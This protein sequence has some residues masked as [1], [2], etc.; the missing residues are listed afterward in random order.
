MTEPRSLSAV[1]DEFLTALTRRELQATTRLLRLYAPVHRELTREAEALATELY[2]AQ[3]RGIDLGPAATARQE[4]VIALRNQIAL[5]IDRFGREAEIT[6]RDLQGV[7]VD[8]GLSHSSTLMDVGL[9]ASAPGYVASFNRLASGALDNLVGQFSDGSPLRDLFQTF[10]PDA[11]S[12]AEQILFRTLATG[13]H[14]RIAA[15]QLQTRLGVP[16]TRA[17]AISRTET[18][19]SY[20]EANRQSFVANRDV[21]K[22]WRWNATLDRR[23]C[24]ACWGQHGTWHPI[25]ERMS[26]HVGGRCVMLPDTKSWAELGFPEVERVAPPEPERNRPG[27]QQF[28]RLSPAAQRAIV[29]PGKLALLESG[30]ITLE[31]LVQEYSHP[32]WG[33]T[34]HEAS[35]A[36]ALANHNQP[37]PWLRFEPPSVP[38]NLP[39]PQDREGALSL[40]RRI[41]RRGPGWSYRDIVVRTAQRFGVVLSLSEVRRLWA[42]LRPS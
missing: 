19:R 14:P 16:L 21:V 23:T 9:A 33:V 7:G 28:A 15:R 11:A 32:R 4:R 13:Q 3:Q 39:P 27:V 10:G 25:D 37:K 18:F 17:M 30:Q 40:A 2:E 42:Q 29:G 41:L 36:Q 22:G 31:D 26:E 38:P 5:R 20:R 1:Q 8:L 6:A 12:E 24:A 35:I 34:R